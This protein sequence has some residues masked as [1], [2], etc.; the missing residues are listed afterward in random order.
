MVILSGIKILLA[1]AV[2][3]AAGFFGR[4]WIQGKAEL[5]ARRKAIRAR[6][7]LERQ[8]SADEPGGPS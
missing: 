2:I 6:L 7:A 1:L 4:S 3:V 8:A 5:E